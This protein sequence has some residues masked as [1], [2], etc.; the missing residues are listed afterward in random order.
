M[1][2]ASALA[3]Y[4]WPI[5]SQN[6]S[7]QPGIN[8]TG[9]PMKLF[10][11]TSLLFLLLFSSVGHAEPAITKDYAPYPQ[12]DNGYVTDLAGLLSA[13]E[14]EQIETWLWQ[15]EYRTQV[16]IIVMTIN[17]I[18]DYPGTDNSTIETFATGLFNTYGIG[19]LPKN[20]GILL[21]V[22][23]D[24]RKVRIELGAYYGHQRDADAQ[25]II[26]NEILPAFR[27]GAYAT[28]IRDGTKAII[29]GF[30]GMRI[31]FPWHIVWIFGGGTAL[32]LIGLS[33]VK[34]GKKGWGYVV[35][36]L[37]IV[38]ILFAIYLLVQFA[39]QLPDSSSSGWSAGGLGGFGGGSSGGGGASGGW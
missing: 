16:E 8:I 31:G 32:F 15:V 22:A 2:K 9:Y 30:T 6:I 14:E 23:R 4:Y 25:R 5:A 19:N 21:L 3:Y 18:Y 1:Q 37:A 10:L 35:I 20:D 36:G 33:L 28:G 29:S 39:K 12:P 24:D 26:D 38:I 7:R 34:S 11:K 17:S 13:D 27:R